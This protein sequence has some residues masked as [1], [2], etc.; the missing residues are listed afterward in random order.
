MLCKH[1]LDSFDTN[2]GYGASGI[3]FFTNPQAPTRE[4]A[5]DF[6]ILASLSQALVEMA[7][8]EFEQAFGNSANLDDYRW[9]K[10]HR[11]TFSHPLGDSLSVPNGMFGLSTVDG[12]SGVA[13]SGGYQV[14]DASSHSVRADGSNEFMFGSGPARRFVAEVTELGILAEQIIP[15]GQSGVITSGPNYV[16]QL[17]LWLVNGY[18]PLITDLDTIVALATE[19]YDFLP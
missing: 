6:V 3:N 11:I 10:L 8:F 12:V 7:G 17:F 14:L 15:G 5:R 1:L 19:E 16:N 9:G 13:R 4:D 18:L 2:Q